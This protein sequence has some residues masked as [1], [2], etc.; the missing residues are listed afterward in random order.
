[1]NI[2]A[3]KIGNYS[4]EELK[5]LLRNDEKFRKRGPFVCLL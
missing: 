2:A 5:A 1:M 4:S 3:L